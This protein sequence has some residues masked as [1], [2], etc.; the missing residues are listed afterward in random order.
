MIILQAITGDQTFHVTPN[1]ELT[2]EISADFAFKDTTTDV[3]ETVTGSIV[4]ENYYGRVTLA[5]D[6]LGRGREY[7]LTV[8]ANSNIILL[9]QVEVLGAGETPETY[10]P[11]GGKPT[12]EP[13]RRTRTRFNE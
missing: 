4:P 12:F 8:T 13:T 1:I 6:F 11:N 10:N 5:L 3:V 2:S 7:E 9:A